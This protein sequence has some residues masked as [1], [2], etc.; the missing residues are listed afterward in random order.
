MSVVHLFSI[1]A[2]PS[3]ELE[4]EKDFIEYAPVTTPMPLDGI[5]AG[6]SITGQGTV[7]Y[8]INTDSNKTITLQLK[9]FHVPGLETQ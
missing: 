9:Y 7:E 8:I 1:Q 5:A 3:V 2:H 6:L 4:S